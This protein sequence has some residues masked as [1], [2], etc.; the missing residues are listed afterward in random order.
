MRWI[1]ESSTPRR[2]RFDAK[3]LRNPCQPCHTIPAFLRRSTCW[4]YQFTY[5]A[6]GNLHS[7]AGL[8]GYGSCT[9]YSSSAAADGNNHLT[10]LS[11]D[12][13][14]NTASNGINNY[15]WD[16]ESQ[17]TTAA[18]VTYKYDGE[19]RRAAKVGTKLYRYGSGGEILSETD[20]SG[21]TQNDYIFFGGKRVALVPASGSALL[22][23]RHAGQLSRHR[24]I[25]RH[26]VGSHYSGFF[27]VRQ[28]RFALPTGWARRDSS[29]DRLSLGR[30]S[31][32]RPQSDWITFQCLLL[33]PQRRRLPGPGLLL[34]AFRWQGC[35]RE[36]ES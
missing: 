24:A 20:A 18:G 16:A 4:G 10:G 34:L 7:Q 9:E 14:G 31:S 27:S 6:W 29:S 30:L 33:R 12:P 3:P 13:S 26:A 17:L 28:P 15:T 21:N 1:T 36:A 32:G 22:R 11:Y 5:D 35:R 8:T 2:F 23:R 19:G 25:D